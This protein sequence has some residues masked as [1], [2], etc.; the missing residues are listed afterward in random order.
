MAGA[1]A[2]LLGSIVFKNYKIRTVAELR[3]ASEEQEIEQATA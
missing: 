2:G 3:A 1:F